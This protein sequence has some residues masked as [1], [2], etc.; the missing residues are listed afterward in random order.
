M[1]RNATLSPCRKYRYLLTRA[2]GE[3]GRIVTWIMLNPSTADADVDDPTIRRCMGFTQ[4]LGADAL[5]V[6][7]LF[8]YR[9]TDPGELVEVGGDDAVGPDNGGNVRAACNMGETIIAAWGALKNPLRGAAGEIVALIRKGG[10]ALKCLG[11]TKDGS[12]RH[13]LYVRADAPLM[14]WPGVRE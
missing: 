8:G 5:V 14:D 10:Y 3:N 9:A 6:V 4:R 12:P 2:W 7:N 13:P 11:K 1:I